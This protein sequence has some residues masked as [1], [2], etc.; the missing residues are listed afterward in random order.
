M[1]HGTYHLPIS[2]DET[3]ALEPLTDYARCKVLVERDVAAMADDD[4]SPTFLRNATV[5]FDERLRA[6]APNQRI[7]SSSI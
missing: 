3:A 4:F 6:A 1:R 2:S 7:F 5:F